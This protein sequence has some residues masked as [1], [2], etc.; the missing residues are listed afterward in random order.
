MTPGKEKAV[1]R[2]TPDRSKSQK[3]QTPY[4]T[5]DSPAT[6]VSRQ[7]RWRQRNPTAFAAHRAVERAVR[8]GDLKPPTKCECGCGRTGKLDAH[9]PDHRE[10]LRVVW[11][12]RGC[13]VREHR[14]LRQNGGSE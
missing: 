13:H 4:S 14:R 5:N 2:K 3:V 7:A 12:L 9:H 11:L 10:P 6:P 8:R 1:T